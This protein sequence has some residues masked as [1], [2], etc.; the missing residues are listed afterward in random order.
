M[1]KLA[2][3][4]LAAAL[5]L[6]SGCS[7]LPPA[8]ASVPASPAASDWTDRLQ[9]VNQDSISLANP[10]HG[11]LTCQRSDR[12]DPEKDCYYVDIEI[13]AKDG[14]YRRHIAYPALT[15]YMPDSVEIR[16][17]GADLNGDGAEDILLDLGISG[18]LIPSYAFAYDGGSDCFVPVCGYSALNFPACCFGPDGEPMIVANLPEP[19]LEPDPEYHFGWNK[20]VVT[21][22]RLDLVATVMLKYEGDTGGYITEKQLVDGAWKVIR[23]HVREE[24]FDLDAWRHT[25]PSQT[26]SLSP[27]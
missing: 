15:G 7:G 1:K 11:A 10:V 22:S 12:Y 19:W 23:S 2:L 24:E 9:T 13:R 4:S 5:A 16:L 25:Y 27:G 14:D 6:C 8:Q 3:F 21:G 18:R 17:Q 20:Y 26:D